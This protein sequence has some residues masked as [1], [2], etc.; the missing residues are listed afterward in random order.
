VYEWLRTF[1]NDELSRSRGRAGVE[2]TITGRAHWEYGK[3]GKETEG[4]GRSSAT[5][6][7]GV[8]A[9]GRG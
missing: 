5:E 4:S 7:E 8:G 6:A 3:P 2:G 1:I 9:Q